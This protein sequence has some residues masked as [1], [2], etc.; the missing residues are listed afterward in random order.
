MKLEIACFDAESAGLAAE[1][2]A[3]RIELC[4]NYSLGGVT[5]P[6][7]VLKDLKSRF[8][9]PVYVMIRPRG[10]DFV[11]SNDEFEAMKAALST[12]KDNG[13]DGFVFGILNKAD[14]IN[15]AQNRELVKLAGDKPCTFHRAFDR[16][17]DKEDA[18]EK[19]IEI[20]FKTVLTSGGEHPAVEGISTLKAL[21]RQAKNRITI[22]VGGGIRSTNVGQFRDF[23]FV[24]SASVNPNTAD[25]NLEELKRLRAEI[26]SF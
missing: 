24:H 13:A 14:K 15:T 10:G 21:H 8:D 1:N 25:L 11:Y 4:D 23:D 16:I 19:L 18:L 2:G 17:G 12:Y 7:A 3:D 26:D 6:L 20:G 9:L 5:P 22:L